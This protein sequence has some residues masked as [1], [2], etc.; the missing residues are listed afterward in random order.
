MGY[1]RTAV[2]SSKEFITTVLACAATAASWFGGLHLPLADVITWGGAPVAVGG[3]VG[4]R[5]KYLKE[6]EAIIKKHPMAYLYAAKRKGLI[7][8]GSRRVG[9]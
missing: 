7:K 2:L 9:H 6:R 3:L 5:S 4:I 8:Q 1:A